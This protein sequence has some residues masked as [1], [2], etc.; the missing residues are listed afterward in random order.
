MKR[1]V[2][3]VLILAVASVA[4]GQRRLFMGSTKKAAAGGGGGGSTLNTS[5]I[6]YWKLDEASGSRSDSEP[7]GTAQ[8][9]SD[10]GTTASA[11][12]K[13]NN[14]ADFEFSSTTYL[15]RSDSSDLSLGADTDF[16]IAG[17]VK[18]ESDT[19]FFAGIV[20]KNGG[21]DNTDEYVVLYNPGLQRFQFK[22][23]NGSSSQT[24]TADNL[25][26]PSTATWYH[27]V[28]IHDSTAD[29]IKLIINNGTADT[30]SWSGGTQ[31]GTA[32]FR[33]GA[34]TYNGGLAF[35]GI[36]DEVG[37]WKKALSASEITELYNSGS[38]KTCCGF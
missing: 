4:L 29:Q 37:F 17:W 32:E 15:S 33:I 2:L 28:A 30:A 8:N 12:G 27:I 7:T 16:T 23:A 36:I 24:V 3:L 18:M 34:M 25:G 13:I 38:G 9:L 26:I 31:D 6:A 21:A 11:T 19:G 22:V 5:L 14:G 1:I 10:S 35:D 20:A